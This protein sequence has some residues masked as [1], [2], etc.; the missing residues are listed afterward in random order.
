MKKLLL[1]FIPLVFFFGCEPED[2]NVDNCLLHGNWNVDYVDQSD[3]VVC[4]CEHIESSCTE[5]VEDCMTFNFL[6][7]GEFIAQSSYFDSGEVLGVWSGDCSSGDT[8]ILTPNDDTLNVVT[9]VIQTISNNQL[10]CSF[11]DEEG[12]ATFFMTK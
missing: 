7:N 4:Y 11:S 5:T 9:L 10:V 6:E 1:L 3:E 2:E 12:G 8:V